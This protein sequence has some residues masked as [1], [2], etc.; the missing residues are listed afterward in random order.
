LERGRE[1]KREGG[2]RRVKGSLRER[3]RERESLREKERGKGVVGDGE[4]ER[5]RERAPHTQRGMRLE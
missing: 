1:R 3:E 2:R 4:K 5:E